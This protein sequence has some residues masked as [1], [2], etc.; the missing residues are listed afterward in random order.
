[1]KDNELTRRQAV[2]LAAG[3]AMTLVA[4]EQW[5][6]AARDGEVIKTAA[7]PAGAAWRP[8]LLTE[9]EG[10]GLAKLVEAL[11]PRTGTPGARDARV[12]E[13]ID[14]A[15]SLAPAAEKKEFVD[16]FRWLDRQCR[17]LHDADLAA[18]SD[19]DLVA[20]LHSISD[21]HADHPKKLRRGARF[22][23]DLKRRTIFGYYTSL[24]GRVQEL[25]LPDTVSMQSWR[26]CAH[27]GGSHTT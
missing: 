20:L 25:G 2:G 21:E 15:V 14:L 3:V 9:R 17:R 24:E 11:I 4:R 5:A 8:V 1:M 13:Y 18:A 23:T 16:G 22:F 6:F 12:H 27:Q 7:D 19:A 10:E 26:G